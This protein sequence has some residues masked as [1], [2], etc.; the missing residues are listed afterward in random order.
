MLVAGVVGMGLKPA[1]VAVALFCITP[2]TL[3]TN[4]FGKR[5]KGRYD[6]PVK[7]AGR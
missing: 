5:Y 3:V 7:Q 6:L 1:S 4:Y 2:T